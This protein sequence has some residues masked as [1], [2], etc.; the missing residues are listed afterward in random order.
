M[1]TPN[2]PSGRRISGR[3]IGGGARQSPEPEAPAPEASAPEGPPP[4]PRALGDG[5]HG[6]HRPTYG[7]GPTE[8]PPA[9]SPEKKKLLIVVGTV[10]LVLLGLLGKVVASSMRAGRIERLGQALSPGPMNWDEGK[11]YAPLLVELKDYGTDASSA[12]PQVAALLNNR[13]MTV[14]GYAPLITETLVAMGTSP[15]SPCC[16]S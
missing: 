10:A 3:L 9:L 5:S 1:T 2:Q 14:E 4:R 16:T 12:A 6:G 15:S 11:L 13:V 7:P 8:A